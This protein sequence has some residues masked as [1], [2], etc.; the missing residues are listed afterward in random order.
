MENIHQCRVT[1][2]YGISMQHNFG[3]INIKIFVDFDGS[4]CC[5]LL[6]N[7]IFKMKK[8]VN[9]LMF[10]MGPQTGAFMEK[11]KSV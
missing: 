7:L 8:R 11:K 2:C 1:F 3:H 6:S 10:E 9:I 4:K 5:H